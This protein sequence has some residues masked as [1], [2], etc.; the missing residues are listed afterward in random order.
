MIKINKQISKF[1]LLPSSKRLE[2]FIY[3][4][5]LLWLYLRAFC[6]IIGWF[7]KIWPRKLS[8]GKYL[9]RNRFH[10]LPAIRCSYNEHKTGESLVEP[11]HSP[12]VHWYQTKSI[13][14]NLGI[15]YFPSDVTTNKYLPKSEKC[16]EDYKFS[17]C[18]GL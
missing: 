6:L 3:K 12:I 8:L 2:M 10:Y 13:G 18:K 14:V 4:Y 16:Q 1:N 15:E 11:R 17:A 9:K 5:L 7:D